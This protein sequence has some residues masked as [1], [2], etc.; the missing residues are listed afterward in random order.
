[1]QRWSD[2]QGH[3]WRLRVRDGEW[4]LPVT[5]LLL[6]LAALAGLLPGTA[7]AQ[8]FS[9]GVRVDFP[10]GID[11]TSVAMGDLNGDG[12]PDLATED[13]ARAHVFLCMLAYY[14]ESH[15]RRT[16]A[17]LLFD[18]EELTEERKHRDPVAPA[19]PSA[20]AKRINEKR[21]TEDG[22]TVQSYETMLADLATRCRNRCRVGDDPA[23]AAFDQVTRATPLQ[24]RVFEL[25]DV[26]PVGSD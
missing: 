22:M 12:R 25:L 9:I 17:P 20:A 6:V 7:V 19:Q 24:A 3:A 16:S 8:G 10:T 13:H 11:P 21:V 2:T 15:L 1:M 18:D 26:Y 5:T 14:I 4:L 23:V